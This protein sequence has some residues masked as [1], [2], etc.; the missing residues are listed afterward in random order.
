MLLWQ[1][2]LFRLKAIMTQLI[3]GFVLP[4]PHFERDP[5][6]IPCVIRLPL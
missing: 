3:L 4:D 6:Q 2:L 5:W 1:R